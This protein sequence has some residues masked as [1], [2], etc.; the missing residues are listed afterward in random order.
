MAAICTESKYYV[1]LC[2]VPL[3]GEFF[4]VPLYRKYWRSVKIRTVSDNSKFCRMTEEFA[5]VRKVF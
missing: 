3:A 2:G 5:V 1:E 4:F